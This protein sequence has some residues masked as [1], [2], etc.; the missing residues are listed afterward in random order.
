[1]F[2]SLLLIIFSGSKLPAYKRFSHLLEA[3][4]PKTSGGTRNLPLPYHFKVLDEMFRCVDVVLSLKQKR[5]ETCTFEKL[6]DSV[7]EMCRK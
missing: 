6:K 3:K 5:Y 4:K 7:Q 1:M 2:N